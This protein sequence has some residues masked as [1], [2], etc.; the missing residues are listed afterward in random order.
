MGSLSE[1]LN[2]SQVERTLQVPYARKILDGMS[3][4][5]KEEKK[6]TGARRAMVL[7]IQHLSHR[8]GKC[9]IRANL[10]IVRISRRNAGRD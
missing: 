1:R 5:G 9:S 6:E 3:D 4:P 7:E 2:I 8:D 10:S